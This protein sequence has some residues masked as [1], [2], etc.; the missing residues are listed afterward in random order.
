MLATRLHRFLQ[1]LLM[2]QFNLLPVAVAA[3]ATSE[4]PSRLAAGSVGSDQLANVTL[5][6]LLVLGLIFALAWLFR[7]YGNLPGLNRSNMQILGGVSLGSR[8]K[9]VLLEV[10]GERLLV[11]VAAGQV[12]KLHAFPT[13]K[14]AGPAIDQQPAESDF[15][16][17]LQQEQKRSDNEAA[18]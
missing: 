11:G 3:E 1:F 6:L 13:V 5:G 17:T 12:T 15:A 10:E 7:R 16:E 18:P 2:V 8:E 14:Q 4:Q 9:A